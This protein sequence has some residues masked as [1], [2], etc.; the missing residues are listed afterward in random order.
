[1]ISAAP[2]GKLD[3]RGG[4]SHHLAHH[5]ADVAAC[6]LAI[7]RMPLFRARLD[8]AAGR[9]LSDVDLER[10]GVVVFLH[11][12]GKLYPGFQAKGWPPGVRTV[13]MCG[14]VKEGLEFFGPHGHPAAKAL[15]VDQLNDWNVQPGLL[16][17]VISHHGRPA[18]PDDELRSSLRIRQVWVSVAAYDP[19]AAAVELGKM[20][21][22]WFPAAFAGDSGRGFPDDAPAFDHLICGL[23]SLADWVGS[24]A[25]TFKHVGALDRSY[26]AKATAL[27]ADAV[28]RIG[29]DATGQREARTARA[30]FL[31]ISGRFPQ[32]NAQQQLIA[33][34]DPDA[35][36]VILEAETGSG[37]TEAAIWRYMRLFEAGRVDG[38]Y[39]AVPT[40]A[41]AAQLHARVAAAAQRLFGEVDPEPV[42]AVPGYVRAGTAEGQ[43]L[44]HWR[45]LWDDEPGADRIASRWAAEH[46]TRFLAAQIA[47]GTVDQAMLGALKIKHAHLRA[48]SLSRSLLVIDE[49]HASDRYMTAIQKRLL[50]AHM[51]IGGYAML[52]SATLGS[53]ARTQWL[54]TRSPTFEQAVAAP[55]P[56]IWTNKLPAPQAPEQD[57]SRSKSVV[58]RRLPTMAP[59]A[60]A[61]AALAAARQGARV[62][63]IRNTVTRAVATLQELEAI[64]EPSDQSLRFTID[65]ADSARVATLHHSRFAPTDRRRLDQA[66]EAALAPKK[67]RA[68]GGKIIIGSQTLEQ[69]LDIDADLL[70]TDLCPVDVL[71]QRIGRLHRHKLPRPAGFE[72]PVC[73][74]MEP[75]DG[76][77]RLLAP[78]FENG[79]G[80]WKTAGGLEGVYRDLCIL[81]LTRNL[82]DQHATWTIPAMNR[83]LVESATHPA[84]IKAL[85]EKLGK[86]WKD[87]DIGLTGCVT[88]MAGGA[89]GIMIDRR[90]PFDALAFPA[91]GEERIRTRLGAEGLQIALPAPQPA[92][93][94][95][96]TLSEV[97]LPAHFSLGLTPDDPVAV[98]DASCS[99]F[100][101]SVGARSFRYDRFGIVRVVPA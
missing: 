15:L 57:A 43:K 27:A 80:A 52:M 85:T 35:R 83:M 4:A 96:G 39:F 8:R 5:C 13:D 30:T 77:E 76:L 34:T 94:F 10:L 36:L 41:A 56:A 59:M 31:E 55:Y 93:P 19:Q 54:G 67:D 100:T 42:L 90:D 68:P 58:M 29:L 84:Q 17:A 38:L 95:G 70:I 18:P 64:I 75:E 25:G 82:V 61:A 60:T 40:R 74:V 24:D 32:P 47:V 44:P 45:V 69:S 26:G 33:D 98:T 65:D 14:H 97:V 46:A 12:A 89:Q 9:P 78:A 48:A 37:K 72:V 22:A 20:A 88:A 16:R 6:F 11:D 51:A 49:V 2:W 92:S 99:G 86:A 23:A 28:R 79:L 62:L 101:F 1:M 87:Y 66:A 3:Q 7:V 71:L 21:E 91:A 50:D 63:V 73:I 81:E 53:S